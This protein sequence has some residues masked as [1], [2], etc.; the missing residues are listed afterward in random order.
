DDLF[1]AAGQ[2]LVVRAGIGALAVLAAFDQLIQVAR[3]RQVAGMRYKNTVGA[4]S[5]SETPRT[6]YDYDQAEPRSL[7]WRTQARSSFVS[8]SSMPNSCRMTAASAPGWRGGSPRRIGVRDRR[9]GRP[10]AIV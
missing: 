6:D 4:V 7:T 10:G 5:H 3:T 1:D 8:S 2:T 9:T